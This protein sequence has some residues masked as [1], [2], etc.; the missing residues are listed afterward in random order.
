MSDRWEIEYFT[1]KKGN[2]PVREF[3]EMPSRI[4]ITHIEAQKLMTNLNYLKYKGVGPNSGK[5]EKIKGEENLYSLRILTINNP[6]VLL[7]VRIGEPN[8]IVLLHA[9]KEKSKSDYKA[10]INIA[11]QRR[12]IK[13]GVL[14]N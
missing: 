6:R 14:K 4:G 3:F 9:F 7:C 10:A 5:L 13:C 1:D 11:R 12:D 2:S 8:C